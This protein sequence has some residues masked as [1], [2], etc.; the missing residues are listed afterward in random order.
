MAANSIRLH[1]QLR[2]QQERAHLDLGPEMNSDWT[3]LSHVSSPEPVTVAKV[4]QSSDWSD[5]V[6]FPSLKHRH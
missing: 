5:W 2:G 6:S 4:I 3:V 1:S